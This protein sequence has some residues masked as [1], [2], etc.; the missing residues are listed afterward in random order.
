MAFNL[1]DREFA[2]KYDFQAPMEKIDFAHSMILNEKDQSYF[3]LATTIFEYD[4]YLQLLKG[5]LADPELIRLGTKIPY[6]FHNEFSYCDLFYSERSQELIA[7]TILADWDKNETEITVHKISYPP[8][9]ADLESDESNS[10]L[11]RIMSGSLFFLFIAAVAFI[12]IGRRKMKETPS[13]RTTVGRKH[14]R[15]GED[16]FSQDE[17]LPDKPKEPAN[18]IIFFGGF[19]VINKHGDDITK[20]FTPLLKELF[21]L[22]F[23]HS[24]ND[25]GISVPR[26]TEIL[27][28]TMD[29]KTAKNNRAVNIAKL[30]SLLSEVESCTLSR[31]TSYW[32]MVFN[33]SLVYSDYWSCMK[34]I[35]HEESFSKEDLQRLLS[36]IRKGPLLG[37]AS[38][39]W[40]DVFKLDCSNMIIDHLMNHIG[41]E[42]IES[43][44]ESMVQLA[45]AILI[46]DMMHEEAI[47]IKCKALTT[48]GKHSL[49]KEFFVKFTKDY[50]TLYDE[51]FERSFTDMIRY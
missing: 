4:T 21:L 18:S 3:V 47:S 24:I 14:E 15:E 23:L 16:K 6:K 43:D 39:E 5:N 1:K 46:F 35:N 25:K 30:K 13:T 37:N 45:D 50:F 42:E 11:W 9:T 10:P 51:A 17:L 27:W 40:L 7:V 12:L 20:K 36:I 26:L 19:Q 22:I 38:Y 33:D 31:K 29:T 8:F 48:L 2:R 41:Q 34:S 44:P 28:F 32:Q 49:A